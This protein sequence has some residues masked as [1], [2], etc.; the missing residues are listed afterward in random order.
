[1]TACAWR[2]PGGG[3]GRW[4]LEFVVDV[5]TATGGWC[6]APSGFVIIVVVVVAATAGSTSAGQGEEEGQEEGQSQ[7]FQRPSG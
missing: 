1:M 5:S 7:V 2:T 4:G 3:S 6:H